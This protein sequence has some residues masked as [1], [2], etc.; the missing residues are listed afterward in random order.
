MTSK[1]DQSGIDFAAS[2]RQ[3]SGVAGIGGKIAL[4]GGVSAPIITANLT[5]KT[6]INI[7][8]ITSPAPGPLGTRYCAESIVLGTPGSFVI[9]ARDNAG[10]AVATDT[11][12]VGFSFTD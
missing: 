12:T 9:Q 1:V 5:A 2:R 7:T 3:Q 8:P 11:C 6:V 10:A 4:V